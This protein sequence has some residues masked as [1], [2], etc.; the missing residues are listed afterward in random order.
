MKKAGLIGCGDYL[1]WEIP[2]MLN[3]KHFQIKSTFDLDK[4]K[5]EKRAAELG[6]TAV[7]SVDDI[8]NDKD[9]DIVCLF[10]PPWARLELF[11]KAVKSGKNIITTKPLANNMETATKLLELTKG[12]VK[13][14]VFYGRAGNAVVE[15]LKKVYDS[16]EIG[17]LALYKEDWF[18]HYPQWNN[19]ATDREKNGGP[20]MDAMIHNLNKSR[21]LISSEPS[22][23]SYTSENFAQKLKC[24]DTESMRVNFKNGSASYLFI[25][26]A[27]DLEVFSLDGMNVSIMALCI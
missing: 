10:T 20:F 25:T 1:R 24:N 8:F 18:H 5:S 22:A 12:K 3:S 17:R 2:H 19:W 21:Y 16:G 15:T 6:A 14:A 26:W 11:E 9:I 27:A 23:V 7:S 4:V 13:C